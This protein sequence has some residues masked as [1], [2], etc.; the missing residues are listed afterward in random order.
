MYVANCVGNKGHAFFF[1]AL[2]EAAISHLPKQNSDEMTKR[3][4]DCLGR[5]IGGKYSTTKRRSYET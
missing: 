3:N 2:M 4:K 1:T 5:R